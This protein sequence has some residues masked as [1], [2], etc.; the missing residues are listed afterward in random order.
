MPLQAPS[1]VQIGYA[2]NDGPIASFTVSLPGTPTP[3]NTV[4][5]FAI[6]CNGIFLDVLGPPGFNFL[7]DAVESTYYSV[8][9]YRIVQ[10]GDGKDYNIY[11]GGDSEFYTV[12][13][14]AVVVEITG[15]PT[16]TAHSGQANGTPS[17]TGTMTTSFSTLT[18]SLS[19][20]F[21]CWD[22]QVSGTG[23]LPVPYT[24]YHQFGDSTHTGSPA[25]Y[26]Y[27]AFL[28]AQGSPP[29]GSV[30]GTATWVSTPMWASIVAGPVSLPGVIISSNPNPSIASTPVLISV[31]VIGNPSPIPTGTVT[32]T[33]TTTSTVLG[34]SLPLVNGQAS[35]VAS[36]L[37]T[38]SHNIIANYSGDIVYT[39]LSASL[40][41]QVESSLIFASSTALNSTLNPSFFGDDVEFDITVSPVSP[42]VVQS[43]SNNGGGTTVAVTLPNFPTVGNILLAFGGVNHGNAP[44]VL[45]VEFDCLASF[46]NGNANAVVGTHIVESDDGKAW[47]FTKPDSSDNGAANDYYVIEFAGTPV[48]WAAAGSTVSTYVSVGNSLLTT[49]VLPGGPGLAI[50]CFFRTGGW[51][52]LS[53]WLPSGYVKPTWLNAD[54][55]AYTG[56]VPNFAVTADISVGSGAEV[57]YVVVQVFGG[58]GYPLGNVTLTDDVG[59]FSPQTLT[60]SSG[61]TSY[62]TTAL[63]ID[64]HTITATYGGGA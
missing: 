43:A 31:D 11:I 16:L 64:Y 13:Q 50:A 23:F 9:W 12:V 30:S 7:R 4:I 40:T 1:I 32:I 55:A 63:A 22:Q 46:Y 56:M 53:N 20:V 48:I 35:C 45:P 49:P 2:R 18:P 38:G 17:T 57:P 5:V 25:N 6:G 61:M 62:D 37:T 36:S 8:C 10:A 28:A 60:L 58:T 52:N 42:M 34:S 47:T 3:G 44:S 21:F 24:V 26:A 54:A 33:D 15:Q 39:P 19:M 27:A 14:N 51:G 29:S 59:S 41:Q